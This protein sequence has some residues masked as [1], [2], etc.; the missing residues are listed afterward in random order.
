MNV[1]EP[2]IALTEMSSL[3]Q[4]GRLKKCLIVQSQTVNSKVASCRFAIVDDW[5]K[6]LGL[7]LR[8]AGII[9]GKEQV[10]HLKIRSVAKQ[11]GISVFEVIRQHRAGTLFETARKREE[12]A[13][14]QKS[15]DFIEKYGKIYRERAKKEQKTIYLKAHTYMLG[16]YDQVPANMRITREGTICVREEKGEAVVLTQE[17]ENFLRTYGDFFRAKAAKEERSIDL[18]RTNNTVPA[19]MHITPEGYIFIHL[20]NSKSE[21]APKGIHNVYKRAVMIDPQG[22]RFVVAHLVANFTINKMGKPNWVGLRDVMERAAIVQSMV[23]PGQ[24]QVGLFGSAE[25]GNKYRCMAYHTYVEDFTDGDLFNVMRQWKLDEKQKTKSGDSIIRSLAE[26]HGMGFSHGDIKPQNIFCNSDTGKAV[27]GDLDTA[28]NG[29]EDVIKVD[30]LGWT[31][32]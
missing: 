14:S 21:E 17:L 16:S 9:D 27:L 23:Q 6:S 24:Y 12:V 13:L 7:T 20:K 4:G 29:R 31:T 32:F 8:V 18:S 30:P 26:L 5:R 10:Q 22:R 3:A 11:L 28:N 15:K 1:S 2:L 25:R 19:S